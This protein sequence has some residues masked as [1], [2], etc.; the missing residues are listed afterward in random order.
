VIDTR[1]PLERRLRRVPVVIVLLAALMFAGFPLVW[2]A[3]NSVKLPEEITALPPVWLPSQP[4]LDAFGEAF[5][6]LP[7]GNAFLNSFLI[8]GLSTAAVVTTSTMAG[9]AFAIYEFRFREPLFLLLLAT[10]FV[11]P[12]TTLVPLYWIIQSMGLLDSLIG[13]LV[14]PLVPPARPRSP[15]AARP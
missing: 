1:A 5:R 15:R 7:L 3:S 10:M 12:I 11:P 13:V 14:P 9:W 6:L 8:A 2:L 4:S